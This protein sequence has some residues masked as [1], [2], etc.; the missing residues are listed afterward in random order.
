MPC[1]TK[2]EGGEGGHIL[3]TLSV[4]ENRKVKPVEIVLRRRERG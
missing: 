2:K 1:A 3:D 4:Y